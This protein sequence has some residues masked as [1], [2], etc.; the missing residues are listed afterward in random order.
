M[1]P[2]LAVLA[3]VIMILVFTVIKLFDARREARQARQR[4]EEFR[5]RQINMY[6]SDFNEWYREINE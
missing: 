3:V 2:Y 4:L 1:E 5:I 6:G